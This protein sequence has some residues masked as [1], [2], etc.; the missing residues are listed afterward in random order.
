MGIVSLLVFVVGLAANWR[1]FQ[2]MGRQGWEG[3]IPVYNTYLQFEILYGKGAKMFL[4]LIPFYGLYIAVK[5]YIDLAHAFNQSTG[6]GWGLTLLNPVFGCI[7]GFGNAQYLDG[8]HAIEGDDAISNAL[9]NIA[10]GTA[11]NGGK[12]PG[13]TAVETLK[14]LA[15]LHADGIVTDEEFQEKKAELLKQI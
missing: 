6:F 8:S 15:Q 1:I 5:F 3:V 9:E 11:G 7:L 12:N 14:E 2:K 4:M 10:N 13:M